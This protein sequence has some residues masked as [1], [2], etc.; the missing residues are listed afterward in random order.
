MSPPPPPATTHGPTFPPD[1]KTG[2]RGLKT[3][4]IGVTRSRTRRK[5]H[6]VVVRTCADWQCAMKLDEKH[7]TSARLGLVAVAWAIT[8]ECKIAL[9]VGDPV[10]LVE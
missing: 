8:L 6:G 3:P 2:H 10:V 5:N 9:W 4:G 1:H 7:A